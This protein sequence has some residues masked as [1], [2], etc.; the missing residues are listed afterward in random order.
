MD[1]L[2][3]VSSMT[4]PGDSGILMRTSYATSISSRDAPAGAFTS[5][6]AP[7]SDWSVYWK[8]ALQSTV[9]ANFD[10]PGFPGFPASTGTA[11]TLFAQYGLMLPVTSMS[12]LPKAVTG[13][14][15]PPSAT[16]VAATLA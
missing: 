2:L 6:K 10:E 4:P 5:R 7:F 15:I 14:E 8:G 16:A 9:K 12:T 11:V 1:E 13:K 3:Q